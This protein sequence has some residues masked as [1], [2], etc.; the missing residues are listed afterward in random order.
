MDL[1]GADLSQ[2]F[3][4]DG[5]GGYWSIDLANGQQVQ[6]GPTGVPNPSLDLAYDPVDDVFW[7][8]NQQQLFVV[9]ETTGAGTSIGNLGLQFVIGLGVNLAG[10]LWGFDIAI[11]QYV[12]IDKTTGLATATQPIGFSANFGQGMDFDPSDDQCYLF[13][14]ND[15]TFVP[16]L[17]SCG[18]GTPIPSTLVGNYQSS[19]NQISDGLVELPSGPAGGPPETGEPVDPNR[20]LGRQVHL[21]ILNFQGQDDVCRTWIEVQVIGPEFSKAVLVTWGEPGFCPPQCAG[22]LKVECTG[23]LKPGATWNFL[24]SQVPTGSK[25]GMLFKFTA[26]QISE[27]DPTFGGEDDIVADYMCETLF[28]GVVG[29]CDDWRRFK[30]AYNEGIEFAGLNM[31]QA[32]GKGFL[33]VEVLRHCPGDV[34]PGVEVSSKYNGIAGDHLGAFDPIYGGYGFYVPLLYADKAGFNSVMYIQNGGLE[35]SSIEIWF[36]AQDDCLRA[37]ICEIF[38]LAPGE[39]YQFDAS[40][41]VGPDWQ[42]SA[43]LRSTQ[44]LGIVVDII[45]RDVLMTYAG[46]P[47]AFAYDPDATGLEPEDAVFTMGDPVAYGP[48]MYSEYQGWDTGVQVQNLDPIVNA[49]VKVYFLDRSGDV[50]TTLVDWICPRG[51][52]TY[53]LPVIADLPGN[54][55]GSIRVES[56]EWWTPGAPAVHPPDIVGV[57]T[58]I[59]YSDSSRTNTT[60]AIAYSL[61][62]EHKL[63]RW[64]IGSGFGGV[65]SGVALIGIPSLLK[66]LEGT[67]VTSEVAIVNIIPK[68]G[69]TDFAIFI[70]DQNG[71]LDFVCQKLNEKQVEYIDLQTWGY[72]NTGFK[73]SAIISAVFWEHD[74]FSETGLFIRNL[75]GLGA[76]AIER[77]GTRLG[78]DVPGDEAA[79][80]RGI[81][82]D[83]PN[84][85]KDFD[86][87][88]PNLPNCPGIGRIPPKF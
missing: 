84:G 86:W 69:F 68:P 15:G 73:G 41:C 35:C 56:Q 16:E 70:Y 66:D 27:I 77:T 57:A 5:V 83:A 43:W 71:L 13:A 60:E 75:V 34:T 48:L 80:S 64:Q 21:P 55:V 25:G 47:A 79:G 82:F 54:W 1:F 63:Y 45:G 81:P 6:I 40:D 20:Q 19:A 17:R 37:R 33:A 65:F 14:F 4:I 72:L 50:I 8:C 85:L 49:K 87:E 42:G 52:Q 51:S 30:K 9:D 18:F 3:A 12:S 39:T 58:L 76:V 74:V 61:L 29:D 2:A 53:F 22:P 59:K 88:G 10:E 62:P 36:K 38:T 67:G 24:G 7:T 28:F 44:P 78:E 23:L 31:R 26:K 11:D 32:A 46:E